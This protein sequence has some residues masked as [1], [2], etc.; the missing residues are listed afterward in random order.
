MKIRFICLIL[1]LLNIICLHAQQECV[2]THYSSEDG[3]SEN[4]VMDIL[5]DEKGNMWF[6]TWNGINKFDGYTFHTY[7][8]NL[9]NQTILGSNR[10]DCMRLDKQGY[11]WLQTYDEN[12]FRFNPR[13]EVFEKV[14]ANGKD[15]NGIHIT[16]I[17]IL[18]N[19]NVWLLSRKGGALRILTD[20]QSGKMHTEFYSAQS[21]ELPVSTIYNVFETDG[22]EW[23]LSDNGLGKFTQGQKVPQTYFQNANRQAFYVAGDVEDQIFFGSSQGVVWKYHKSTGKFSSIRL[24]ASSHVCGI[25]YIK[26][27]KQVLIAT[28][29]DGFFLYQPHNGGIQH[30]PASLLLKAPVKSVF[31]DSTGEIW[32]EQNIVGE[33]AHFNPYRKTVKQEKVYV[34]PT[35]TDRSRPAF[36]IHEDKSGQLWVH[37][38]G[39]GF[40]YFDR[41][42]NCLHPFYNSMTDNNWRFSN[43]IHSAFSD[44]QGNLWIGTHSKGLEKATF[45]TEHF[46]LRIPVNTPYE[47]LSNEVRAIFDDEK[48]FLWI[49]L[50]DGML[51]IYD[52]ENNEIGYLTEEGKISHQGTP[53]AGNVYHMLKDSKGTLW[54]A[55]K[56]AGLIKAE[57]TGNR[58]QFKLTR[59]RYD[60]NDK[61][62]LSD[63][64]LYCIYEDLKG[65]IWVVTFSNG[66]NYLAQD[67]KGKTIFINHRNRLTHYPTSYCNK[68]RCITGDSKGRL[69]IG[70]THGLL[71]AD[72]NFKQPED[73]VFRHYL[74]SSENQHTLSNNDIYWIEVTQN[75]ELFMA[76]FGGG[77]NKLIDIDKEGKARFKSYT[78][79]DGLPSDI[80]MSISE[81]KHG[82]LWIGTENGLSK[83]SP[84]EEK[85]EN[86]RYRFRGY[87]LRFCEA[88]SDCLSNGDMMFGTNNGVL[89]FTP[90]SIKKSNYVPQLVFSQLLL[91]NK[92]V[93]PGANSVLKCALDYIDQL[94]LSHKE[95]IFTIQYAAL[96][97]TAPNDI[98]YAYMLEGF[99]NSWNYV[100]KQRMATYTN[101]P[102]GEYTFKVK[103]TNA[104]GVWTDN[105][106]S[107]QITVLPS[108]W[109]TPWAYLLY[110][111]ALMLVVFIAVYILST[112]Y[113]LKHRVV[114]EHQ[115]TDMKL[116]FFTDIS[117]ELRTPLTLISAPLEYI[118]GNKE[119][120]HEI[121][122]Q[123]SVVEKNTNR[124]LRLVNQILD[125]RKIQNKK[126][127]MIVQQMDIVPYTRSIMDNFESLA[128]EHQMQFVFETS[129]EHLFLWVDADKFEK[130]IYNLLSNSFKYTPDG[131]MIRV[132]ISESEDKISIEVED[133]G[134]GIAE[135]KKKVLF[136]RFENHVDS[137]IFKQMST[138]IGLS[139]V[140]DF[141]DMHHASISVWSKVNEGSCFK[142]DFL[143]GK[144][145][146]GNEVEF[147]LDDMAAAETQ[148]VP[149]ST[150]EEKP[151]AADLPY[152]ENDGSLS[153]D[154]MLL[155]E[156][157]IELRG[158]LRTIFSDEYNVIEAVNGADGLEKALKQIPDIIISDVM[159]PVKDGFEMMQDLRNEITTSHIP[160]ILLTAKTAIES[161]LEGL[162]Y[163]ADDYITKPFSATYLKA[164]VKNI[165]MKRRKLQEMF[166]EKLM[167]ASS[168]TQTAE[169][170]A[171]PQEMPEMSPSDKKFMNKLM[172]L[173][174]ANLDNGNLVVDDLVKE[175]AVS[176]SVFFKKLK[177]LT[178]F[179]PVEFIREIRINR[180][181]QLID[182]GEYSITQISYMVG[183]NDPRYFSKCFKQKMG[184]TPTEYKERNGKHA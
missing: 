52:K 89:Q 67:S 133:Q 93:T 78:E 148:Q 167:D 15:G 107:L 8:G 9:D 22:N 155:V 58:L 85:F 27:L 157:N 33:V 73:V 121:K 143:K 82:H 159:M 162:E 127:K 113:R 105:V 55:T 97:Y 184:M 81:D 126:M 140:K 160:L 80:L 180:A 30:F 171:S 174:E 110:V 47:S 13:T 151:A 102:K 109:E 34:E 26:G 108:F 40:S 175:M 5:Q 165:L 69:W 6:S 18:S 92:T 62:S 16:S 61:Y 170:E 172:E 150:S 42:N 86:F 168:Q 88:S 20:S 68:V 128:K 132:K 36:H 84:K 158:F 103:S 24:A 169:K 71:M 166:R 141:A 111:L 87:N 177:S 64:N 118:M 2:L 179:A 60:P 183:I 134:I 25:Q 23:I 44:Q 130:I 21:K 123:L 51:R 35:Y 28:A 59:F 122:E 131:K 57:P 19:G 39:G 95:N 77:L 145:H 79:Y 136:V 98:Q 182:T 11:I 45:R 49:G 104:D 124:M 164:R 31:M 53:L 153:K 101:L 114:M 63:N 138:G 66:I 163:G 94:I 149:A 120:P 142:I 106:R 56:G 137:K 48:G 117:H 74:C 32:F 83:F 100:G 176:R 72:V 38:Y 50:K 3:L 54:I 96:D 1:S 144:E 135:N 178:G 115:L 147:I 29:S 65:R 129:K 99:E 146:Y 17:R 173:M 37:P 75:D 43:K 76:T 90:D 12:I 181:V 70:T 125:F 156:D 119:L 91:A 46:K 14:S 161:K 7:K 139:L 152:A 112:I 4:T 10:I 154:T 116:R 41:K